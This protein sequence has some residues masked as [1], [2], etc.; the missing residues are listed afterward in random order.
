MPPGVFARAAR[1]GVINHDFVLL[2]R[3]FP[4]MKFEAFKTKPDEWE[5]VGTCEDGSTV[6]WGVGG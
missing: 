1:D 2:E 5:L 4:G 3:M 6:S